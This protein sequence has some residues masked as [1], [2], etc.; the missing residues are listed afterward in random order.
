MGDA[1]AAGLP[2]ATH[3]VL[4]VIILSLACER[5]CGAIRGGADWGFRRHDLVLLE[6][7]HGRLL[8]R[9]EGE[10]VLTLLC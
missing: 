5:G 9:T 10:G 1:T 3:R 6:R 7:A 2:R 8:P 4:G